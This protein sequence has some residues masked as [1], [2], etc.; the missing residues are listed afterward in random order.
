[1]GK[2][3]DIKILSYYSFGKVNLN[4]LA[5]SQYFICTFDMDPPCQ[6]SYLSIFIIE[7]L[8]IQNEVNVQHHGL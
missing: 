6:T 8:I 5:I 2:I 1:M 7:L 3:E 4:N